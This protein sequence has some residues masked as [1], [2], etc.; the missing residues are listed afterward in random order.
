MTR[1]PLHGWTLMFPELHP[2]AGGEEQYAADPEN[3]DG[4]EVELV[5]GAVQ[6]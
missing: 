3:G 5:A 6:S 4:F 1:S 2:H